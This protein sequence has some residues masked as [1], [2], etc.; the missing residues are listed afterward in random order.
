MYSIS[1]LLKNLIICLASIYPL[2]IP[3][4][5]RI[6]FSNDITF[7][8]SFYLLFALSSFFLLLII[9]ALKTLLTDKA[10]I[11]EAFEKRQN[12]DLYFY[13]FL[14]LLNAFIPLTSQSIFFII[15]IEMIAVYSYSENEMS[16]P[17]NSLLGYKSYICKVK[18]SSYKHT[19]LSKKDLPVKKPVK[20][21]SYSSTDS[22]F[23][24]SR[25]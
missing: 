12:L 10:L 24:R 8:T 25:L 21:S 19:I 14:G 4:L 6:I 3:L 7:K 23:V 20:V 22:R 18:D 16:Y 5:V 2:L 13:F 9:R 17:I 1:Q 11:I 15:T